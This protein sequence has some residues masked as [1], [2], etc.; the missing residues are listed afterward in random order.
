M[1][2]SMLAGLGVMVLMVPV[3]GVAAKY[4]LPILLYLPCHSSFS[5]PL[6]QVLYLSSH[7]LCL[8]ILVQENGSIPESV[9]AAARY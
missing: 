7:S 1:G 6:I 2:P 5:L 4:T 3:N 8:L 9:D